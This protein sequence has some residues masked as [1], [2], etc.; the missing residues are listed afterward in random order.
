MEKHWSLLSAEPQVVGRI[1]AAFNLDPIIATILVN[2][3]L[4][5]EEALHRFLN[6]GLD[7]LRPPQSLAGMSAAVERILRAIH[8]GQR[9]LVFGD[10]DV[11]GV[12]ATVMLLEFLTQAG[13]EATYYIPHRVREGYG[14]QPDHVTEYA[15]SRDIGLI[16]TVDCGSSCH[17]A[18][19][20][21]KSCGIGVVITDHHSVSPPYPQADAFVN[22]KRHDCNAG[23]DHLSGVGVAFYLA[24]ALRQRLRALGHWESR[25]EPN[26]KSACD[27]VA[28][29]T[30]ADVVPLHDENRVLTRAGL[31]MINAGRRPGLRALVEN[32]SR[33]VGSLDAEDLAFKLAP[34][35]NA[36]GRMAHARQ[37]VA[38]LCADGA[39]EAR[40]LAE[41]LGNLN[42][43]R[44]QIESR[45][46]DEILRRLESSPAALGRRTLIVHG[47]GW[48]EGILGI[49][50][51]RLVRRFCKPAVVLAV[52]DG[53]AKGSARSLPGVDLAEGLAACRDHL[54][55]FGGHALAAGLSLRT[56]NID[57]FA[58]TLESVV[59]ATTDC[60]CFRPQVL[61][62]CE[63]PLKAVTGELIEALEILKPFGLGN[64]EPLF[65]A[66]DVVV[67]SSQIVGRRHRRMGLLQAGRDTGRPLAAIQFNIDPQ[68]P[69]PDFF[70]RMAFRLRWNRWNGS[71]TP[72]LLIEET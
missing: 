45:V 36:A 12:T 54:E 66:R 11:D 29:G 19:Q 28:L 64:P 10:Y 33:D 51:S 7:Q 69:Q 59:T 30:V 65:M 42:S 6:P 16:V 5:S 72:Q 68:Q 46:F 14:L 3:R 25:P 9:I 2:R 17:A 62:D 53:V 15:R 31:E 41:T 27:L 58:Q 61:L 21:A 24:A 50:A 26:L 55:T 22:P 70:P 38:L 63:L 4:Q 37:A 34:R 48:P 1:A 8:Q 44:Q 39:Q 20:A 47:S 56:C 23:L 18:V 40:R 35:L 71:R 67:K 43:S 49:V 57:R 32:C 60:D 13:A 52:R